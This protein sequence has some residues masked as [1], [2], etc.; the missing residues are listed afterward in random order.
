MPGSLGID[1]CYQCMGTALVFMG[2]D[3][4]ARALSGSFEYNG[5]ILT[6]AKKIIYRMEVMRVLKKPAP[7]I[8]A[9]VD[10]FI[11]G[12]ADPIYKLKDAR[13][14]LFREGQLERSSHYQPNW[15]EIKKRAV[16]EIEQSRDYYLNNFG[17]EGF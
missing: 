16:K 13:L 10:L 1:G 4:A 5:Q 11:D 14:S 7:T 9:E 12:K 6:D 17:E 15:E 3:G 8:F 2:F